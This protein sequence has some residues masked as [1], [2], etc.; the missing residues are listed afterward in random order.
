MRVA[1][2]KSD[3]SVGSFI[4]W[5]RRNKLHPIME[6]Y[7][8]EKE[9]SAAVKTGK[10]DSCINF[11]TP[12]GGFRSLLTFGTLPFYVMMNKNKTELAAKVN[13]ALRETMDRKRLISGLRG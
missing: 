10:A 11:N 4:E 13:A 3:A 2:V 6:Y 9:A 8:T 1:V 5:C 7:P 12:Q